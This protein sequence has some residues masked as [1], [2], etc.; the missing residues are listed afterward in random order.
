MKI[1]WGITGAGHYL[2]ESVEVLQELLEDGNEVDVFFSAAGKVVSSMYKVYS[3]IQDLKENKEYKFKKLI[4]DGAQFPAYP[5]S[6]YFNLH[7]YDVLVISPITSNS[8]A[9]MSNGIADTLITNIFAQMIK[10]AGKI[11]CM[12]TDLISGD[13]ETTIPNG[14]SFTIHID[15]FNSENAKSLSKFPN[16]QVFE[17]P[18]NILEKLR[19]MENYA[20]S[21][22]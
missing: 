2:K 14:D 15:E 7:K 1:A 4:L 3:I 11:L 8:V 10:G 22:K 12:P 18:Q 13:I 16:T 20:T 17:K 19:N 6:A 21:E 9:K 5:V